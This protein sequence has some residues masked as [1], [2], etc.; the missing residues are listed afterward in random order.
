M[1]EQGVGHIKGSAMPRS[2]IGTHCVLAGHRGLP[3][4]DLLARLGELEVGDIVQVS[5]EGFL[6]SYRV[7]KVQVIRP[8]EVEIFRAEKERE[9]L[10]I[11]TCTPYG[12]NTHR[13]VVTAERMK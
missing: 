10:S 11:V 6:L 1:L 8:D 7:C 2:G 4:A 9:L 5:V 3:S 12:I 13:L